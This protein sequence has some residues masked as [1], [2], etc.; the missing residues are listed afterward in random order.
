[1]RAGQHPPLWH[2][3]QN[4][5]PGREGAP[6][7]NRAHTVTVLSHSIPWG[8]SHSGRDDPPTRQFITL[9]EVRSHAISNKVHNDCATGECAKEDRTGRAGGA[10]QRSMRKHFSICSVCTCFPFP[11]FPRF[12]SHKLCSTGPEGKHGRASVT[13]TRGAA[14]A[15]EET[16][17]PV[18]VAPAWCTSGMSRK[19]S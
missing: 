12:P 1:M 19:S 13:S 16:A 2:T 4:H 17:R 14:F 6:P 3:W 8:A 10:S 7:S 18:V 11:T 5:S 15:R 9:E